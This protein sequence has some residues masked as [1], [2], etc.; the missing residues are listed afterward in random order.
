MPQAA[1]GKNMKMHKIAGTAVL[2]M[3]GMLPA[4]AGAVAQD[5]VM[6]DDT[7][8]ITDTQAWREADLPYVRLLADPPTPAPHWSMMGNAR[9]GANP[10]VLAQ[11]ANLITPVPETS[12]YSMLLVGLGLLALCV[13]RDKQEKFD[14]G[15]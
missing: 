12:M 6:R 2:A 9:H 4:Q 3:L 5:S 10:A 13:P 11:Q 14:Q 1:R 7:V 8:R 15:R